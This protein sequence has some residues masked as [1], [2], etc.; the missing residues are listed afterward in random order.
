MLS[1][2]LPAHTKHAVRRI[3]DVDPNGE[4]RAERRVADDSPRT[5]NH[6]IRSASTSAG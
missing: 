3:Q 5:I 4:I 1:L 2:K 6:E